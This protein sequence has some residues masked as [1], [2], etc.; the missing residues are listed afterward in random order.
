MKVLIVTAHPASSGFTHKIAAAYKKEKEEHGGEVFVMDLYKK[1][2]AQPFLH[3]E[4]EQTESKPTAA[5]KVIQEKIIWADEIVFVFPVWWFG[6]PAILKNFLDQNFTSGFAY[7]YRT[8]GMRKE[9]LEGRTA[10]IFAT[11]DGSRLVYFIFRFT[12]S[13]RWRNGVLGFCGINLLSMDV[14]AE[15]FKRK[16]AC[17]RERMLH[18]VTERARAYERATQ[19]KGVRIPH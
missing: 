3:Y 16:S 6:P 1:K 9:L 10:R 19:R 12:A 15:M 18:R 14:F 11:A 4:D 8:N 5:H 13:M 2:Y 7:K 17:D